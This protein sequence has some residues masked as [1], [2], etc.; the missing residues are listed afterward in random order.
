MIP[1]KLSNDNDNDII[2]I[3]IDDKNYLI[4]DIKKSLKIN[5]KRINKGKF[6]VIITKTDD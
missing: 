1:R 2:D 6:N 5:L 3:D 4:V